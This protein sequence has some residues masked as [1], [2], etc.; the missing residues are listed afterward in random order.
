MATQKWITLRAERDIGSLIFE[1]PIQHDYEAGT[2]VRSLLLTERL[3]EIDGRLAVTDEAVTDEDLHSLGTSYVKFWVDEAP[4]SPES[5]RSHADE[6]N[7][8]PLASAGCQSCAKDARKKKKS[9]I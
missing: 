6:E 7:T 4:N 2:E 5:S 9:V 8:T 3:E 1:T